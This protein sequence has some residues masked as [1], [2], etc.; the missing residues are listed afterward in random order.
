[1]KSYADQY[2]IKEDIEVWI[3]SHTITQVKNYGASA[4]TL[5]KQFGY[6]PELAQRLS[7]AYDDTFPGIKEYK[8]YVTNILNK[9]EYITN[10]FG[11]RYYNASAH[12]CCNY[13]IQGSGADYLKLKL[14]E[15]DKFLKPYKSR[16]QTTIHDEIGYEIYKGEEFL[17]PQIKAIMENLKGTY[18]PMVSEVEITTTTWDEKK[19]WS[20]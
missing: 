5:I 2:Q 18:V 8:K 19:G 11:R 12:K 6:E 7:Q 17:I 9:Q 10:L 1:M 14:I 20:E 3:K 13:L 16:I 15:L 4:Q